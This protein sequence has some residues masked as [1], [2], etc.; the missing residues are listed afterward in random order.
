MKEDSVAFII[1]SLLDFP[2]CQDTPYYGIS[3][4]KIISCLRIIFE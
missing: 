4:S 2:E 1:R 3:I